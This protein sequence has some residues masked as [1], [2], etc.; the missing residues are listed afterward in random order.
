MKNA[1]RGLRSIRPLTRDSLRGLRPAQP[2]GTSPTFE[3]VDPRDLYVEESYQRDVGERG[4]GLVRQIYAAFDWARFKPPICVRMPEFD[5]VL[6]CI[7]GQHTAI[8]AAS[9]PSID[10]IPVM[11]VDAAT[12]ERRA[13]A[14]V[15]H[16]RDRITL[17]NTVIH[18]AEVAAGEPLAIEVA[19]ACA[20][21]GVTVLVKPGDL[22]KAQVGDT[23]SIG[24]L[25]AIARRQGGQALER[26]LK[27]LVAAKRAPIRSGEVAAAALILAAAGKRPGIDQDLTRVVATSTAEL[28]AA[29]AATDA[30]KNGEPVPAALALIWSAE[31]GLRLEGTGLKGGGTL[32]ATRVLKGAALRPET[33]S[34]KSASGNSP[35]KVHLPEPPPPPPPPSRQEPRPSPSEQP[36]PSK[37]APPPSPAAP[38]PRPAA[39]L[40]P[41]ITL[42]GIAIDLATRHLTHRGKQVRI[43]RDDGVRL[44]VALLRVMPAALGDDRLAAKAFGKD[45]PHAIDRTGVLRML[46]TD[47]NPVLRVARL[48]VRAVGRIGWMLA[49]MEA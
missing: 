29:K 39:V 33:T 2:R 21:A 10:A 23:I 22:R 35:E 8:A 7:D 37:P 38:A 24:A 44:I 13:A 34:S 6:V 36:P 40:P 45:Q 16:N 15:G 11:V 27:V 5:N 42:N 26:V 25:K 20:A 17:T 46:I 30:A 19:K 3:Y 18:R 41:P 43:H 32:N 12:V 14:F 47:I 49:D 28:W 48:E 9:H 4:I 31:L 1:I